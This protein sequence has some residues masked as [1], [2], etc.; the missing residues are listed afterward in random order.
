MNQLDVAG[1]GLITGF[2]LTILA[3]VAGPP[4]LYQESDSQIR[5]KLI[6]DYSARWLASNMLFGLGGL[7]TAAG[8]ILFSLYVRG[9]VSSTI[10]WLAALGYG[11]STVLWLVF[12]YNRQVNPAQLFE[13]YTFSPF[14]VA[15]FGLMLIGLLL[16]GAVYIQVGYPG[17]LGVG[18]VGVTALIGALALLFPRGFFASFPPQI[19]YML[20]LA[21]GIVFLGR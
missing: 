14:T 15:L 21:A 20:T 9:E 19:L 10:N 11:L 16:Y 1:I 12:L 2:I 6:R 3:T 13:E 4:R 17:W 8:L 7:A 18:T 5:L